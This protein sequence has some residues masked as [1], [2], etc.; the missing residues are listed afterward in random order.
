MK[1]NTNRCDRTGYRSIDGACFLIP[2]MLLTSVRVENG[3]CVFDRV[4]VH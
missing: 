3:N 2:T 1:I 4:S